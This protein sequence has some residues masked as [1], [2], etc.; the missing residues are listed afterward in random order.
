MYTEESCFKHISVSQTAFPLIQ[1][2][3]K[4]KGLVYSPVNTCVT[5][6]KVYNMIQ[7]AEK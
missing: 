4:K 6:Y 3:E 2:D 7:L 1:W 5:P